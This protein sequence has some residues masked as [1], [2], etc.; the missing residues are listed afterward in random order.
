MNARGALAWTIERTRPVGKVSRHAIAHA[1]ARLSEK[2]HRI[3]VATDLEADL[4]QDPVGLSFDRGERLLAEKLVGRNSP[5]DVG[6]A[7]RVDASRATT[8]VAARARGR[9][10]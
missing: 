8:T 10:C 1:R 2:L 7:A 3:R 9:V 6:R 5:G 4:G